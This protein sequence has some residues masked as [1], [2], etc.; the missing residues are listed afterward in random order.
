MVRRSATALVAAFL[1]LCGAIA[2]G[3]RF[4]VSHSFPM[5]F[6]LTAAQFCAKLSFVGES[7]E[8]NDLVIVDP[9]PL[10][11]FAMAVDRGYIGK[12]YTRAGCIPLI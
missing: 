2:A 9:P 12:G 11:I 6:Y 8:K 1:L 5:G 7:P 10:P 3:L 4:N